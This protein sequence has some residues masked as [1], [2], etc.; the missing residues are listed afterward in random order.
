MPVAPTQ[1]V[2]SCYVQRT[3]NPKLEVSK[4]RSQGR[5]QVICVRPSSFRKQENVQVQLQ[6]WQYLTLDKR[7]LGVIWGCW[8]LGVRC[9]SSGTHWG[10]GESAILPST[11]TTASHGKIS[12]ALRTK[13]STQHYWEVLPVITTE[14]ENKNAI[15]VHLNQK[16]NTCG[17]QNTPENYL[18]RPFTNLYLLFTEVSLY[19]RQKK[20]YFETFFRT[21]F[22]TEG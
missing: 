19:T 4:R 18:I 2:F 7:L 21:N 1:S 6:L 5:M 20:K 8:V 12:W 3:K 16:L 14:M 11:A 10:S 15:K 9:V 22:S 17:V 13:A